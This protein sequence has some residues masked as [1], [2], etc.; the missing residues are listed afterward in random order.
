MINPIAALYLADMLALLCRTAM[1][2]RMMASCYVRISRQLFCITGEIRESRHDANHFQD[3]LIS[4]PGLDLRED[5]G[6]V[7]F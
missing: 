5:D 1:K 6:P 3:A 4:L 7:C 2:R